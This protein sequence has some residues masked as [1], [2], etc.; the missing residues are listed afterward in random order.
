[1]DNSN[2]IIDLCDESDD[3]NRNPRRSATEVAP[4]DEC[5]AKRGLADVRPTSCKTDDNTDTSETANEALD[6]DGGFR[7]KRSRIESP[8]DLKDDLAI[9]NDKN[10][11]EESSL[12]RPPLMVLLTTSSDP[13]DEQVLVTSN[14]LD[15]LGK[16]RLVF[17]RRPVILCASPTLLHVQQRDSWSCGFRN[18][19]ML[20]SA[21][22]PGLPSTHAYLADRPR[23]S[24]GTMDVPSLN[25]LQHCLE[26]AWARGMDPKGCQH[27]GGRMANTRAQIG[28]VEAATALNACGLDA[29]V[30]Q[31]ISV[32]ES[33][34]QLGSF[35]AAYMGRR[36]CSGSS[37]RELAEG[38]LRDLNV[39]E[40]SWA[41]PQSESSSHGAD[42]AGP[43]LPLYLQYKGH[44]VTIVGVEYDN[45]PVSP[46]VSNLL[47]FDPRQR[48]DQLRSALQRGDLAPFRR[49]V[50]RLHSQDTQVV[51]C[52]PSGIRTKDMSVVTA[53]EGA[54][55]RYRRRR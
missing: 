45:H 53:N 54:V 23:E 20:L 9:K 49:S 55:L 4:A 33:R 39:T 32:Q 5:L 17:T 24:S 12:T 3:E 31:F 10:V 18:L 21:L 34:T 36:S 30:V 2:P 46:K 44:S 14:L 15:F 1:M 51:L 7:S 13:T 25:Q 43:S 22:L 41:P 11:T 50:A 27:Y 40:Q 26:Q 19:Q 37:S 8:T 38:L 35:C 6:P 16:P 48:G 28:A 42:A 52:T 29:T 47:V